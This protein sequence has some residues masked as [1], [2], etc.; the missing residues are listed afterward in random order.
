[1]PDVLGALRINKAG[2]T[3][4]FLSMHL[5]KL[6]SW[7][8]PKLNPPWVTSHHSMHWVGWMNI[9]RGRLR[10][11]SHLSW[12]IQ[13]SIWNSSFYLDSV[14]NRRFFFQGKISLSSE[15]LKECSDGIASH[16]FP[17]KLW[18]IQS[19]Q[20]FPGIKHV[21]SA[22]IPCFVSGLVKIFTNG[23]NDDLNE[24]RTMKDGFRWQN[25]L[26]YN[27]LITA[28]RKW[29]ASTGAHFDKRD[30]RTLVH[31]W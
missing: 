9:K 5:E 12:D 26:D 20:Y 21:F 10:C 24:N 31:R 14:T 3:G 8:V 27:A 25:F 19:E 15:N 2:G 30:I 6:A 17:L 23:C 18:K 4:Q 22:K 7:G 11:A 13:I 1:M 29:F 16:L 28:V